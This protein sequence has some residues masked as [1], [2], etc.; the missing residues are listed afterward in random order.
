MIAPVRDWNPKKLN[1]ATPTTEKERNI[2]T[3]CN[4]ISTVSE[5]RPFAAQSRII[6][7]CAGENFNDPLQ[8]NIETLRH[9]IFEL[10]PDAA[11]IEFGRQTHMLH[12][13][14]ETVV[15][16]YAAAAMAEVMGNV[17]G[18]GT[19]AAILIPM[20]IAMVVHI[21]KIFGQPVS[22]AT[23]QSL[24]GAMLTTI[25]GKTIVGSIVL[26]VPVVKNFVGPPIAGALT[27]MLGRT[28]IDVFS[29][30]RAG[31]SSQEIEA[32]ARRHTHLLDEA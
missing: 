14:A 31:A 19:D 27:K 30:H 3:Y 4:Y 21:G 9:D 22:R 1:L 26:F 5:L 16:W 25:A 17:F 10:L 8:Y 7:V 28:A 32:F 2:S 15:N 29:E 6:P 20:Q 13:S 23:A 11:K 12:E 24:I 18:M